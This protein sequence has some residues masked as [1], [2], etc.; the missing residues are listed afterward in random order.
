MFN[1]FKIIKIVVILSFISLSAFSSENI[2]E[3]QL[4]SIKKISDSINLAKGEYTGSVKNHKVELKE[5]YEEANLF[6]EQV[7]KIVISMKKDLSENKKNSFLEIEKEISDL[8]KILK[9]KE[10]DSKFSSLVLD[11]DNKLESFSGTTL[12]ELPFSKPHIENGKKIFMQNCATC[13]GVNADGKGL[14]SVSFEVKPPSFLDTEFIREKSP[15]TLYRAIKNGMIGTLMPSWEYQLS[16]KEKWDVIEYIRSVSKEK[17]FD[18]KGKELYNK[19]SEKH[20][21]KSIID[22]NS[23]SDT[24]DKDFFDNLKKDNDFKSMNDNE[25]YSIINYARDEKSIYSKS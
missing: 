2:S 3:E 18:K 8:E 13:H 16:I 7:N 1:S 14:A 24:S 20:E 21:I 22:F 15:Y 19:Y 6:I 10:D 25:L 17:D 4:K 5:E 11:I 9:D 23:S 12:K